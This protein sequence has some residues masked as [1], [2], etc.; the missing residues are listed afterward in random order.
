MVQLY[1]HNYKNNFEHGWNVPVDEQILWGWSRDQPGEG[2]NVDR[3]PRGFGPEYKFLYVVGVQVTTTFEHVRSKEVKDKSK[4]T[5]EYG[6]GAASFLRLCESTG[7]EGINRAV[8]ADIWFGDITCV[9]GLSKL[10]LQSIKTIKTR[11]VGYCKQ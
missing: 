3:K 7:I 6:S 2:H 5:K 10:G 8:I 9:L 11:T 4:Y 1:N